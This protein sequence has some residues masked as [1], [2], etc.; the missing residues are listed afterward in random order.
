MKLPRPRKVVFALT[1]LSLL[2]AGNPLWATF[3]VHAANIEVNL[4]DQP[5]DRTPEKYIG[6]FFDTTLTAMLARLHVT[7]APEDKVFIFPD[8]SLGIG[9]Q[10]RIYRATVVNLTD[11]GKSKTIRTWAP[12][13]ADFAAIVNDE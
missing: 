11:A 7:V 13:V 9:S 3:P 2:I 12:T 8:P 1:T 10:I 5:T 6:S 4:P